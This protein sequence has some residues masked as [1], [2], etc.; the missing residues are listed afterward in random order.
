M[1]INDMDFLNSFC[2]C[3]VINYQMVKLFK[4]RME[5]KKRYAYGFLIFQAALLIV[6]VKLLLEMIPAFFLN[7]PL[8]E[9]HSMMFWISFVLIIVMCL[10]YQKNMNI[11]S[12]YTVHITDTLSE[13]DRKKICDNF[14]LHPVGKIYRNKERFGDLYEEMYVAYPKTKGG[15]E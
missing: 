15:V 5:G 7:Q 3:Q 8:P 1:R 9:H 14:F 13:T 4:G 10:C 11:V 2:G 6:V 12:E